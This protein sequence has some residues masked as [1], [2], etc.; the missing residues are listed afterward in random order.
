[1]KMKMSR[2]NLCLL[3]CAAL[4]LPLVILS[5][6]GNAPAAGTNNSSSLK[7]AV[8]T[9]AI[10]LIQ[11]NI[12][13]FE[14]AVP[15]TK[16]E[17]VD[18]NWGQYSA[19]IVANT[20]GG[21]NTPDIMYCSDHWLQQ[22]ASAG[23]IVPIEDYFPQTRELAKSFVPYAIEGMTYNGKL[24]G[25]PYYTDPIGFMYNAALLKQA[26]FDS[27]PGD[28]EEVLKQARAIKQK[29]LAEYPIAFGFSQQEPFGIEIFISM[30][31]SRGGDLFDAK[32]APA[33]EQPGSALEQ[34]IDW[35]R[36]A[37]KEKLINP[38]SLQW[39]GV[40]ATKSMQ[41]GTQV[42]HMARIS[43]LCELNNQQGSNHA[44]SFKLA[45][46]P[47]STHQ[48]VGFVR[49]YALSS[50]TPKKGEKAMNAAWQ[51]LDYF[52]GPGPDKNYPVV[53]RWAVEKGIGFAPLP[54]FKDPEIRA[55][56]EKWGDVALIEEIC[57]KYAKVKQG[58]TPEFAEWDVYARGELQRAYLDQQSASNTARK[59]AAKWR[60]LRK[61]KGAE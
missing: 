60:E 11:D 13:R 2:L 59:L 33:F 16:V 52:G 27:A 21:S 50:Q 10:D 41:A 57:S 56:F 7:F 12:R 53:R 55:S 32:L 31:Y 24:Y 43:E 30:I 58:L 17:L 26:G 29:G 18:Y 20:V 19:S 3:L 9:Y 14:A 49:F 54:L 39:D 40:Q 8:W 51:F 5:S 35:V 38:E 44:G 25:L 45:L 36:L 4:A 37:L 42:F 15:D 47:G 28:W 1:M 23:W 48:T 34:S 46:M 22:W 6:C 61:S